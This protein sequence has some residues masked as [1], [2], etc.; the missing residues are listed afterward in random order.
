[1]PP[2]TSRTPSTAL[3]APLSPPEFALSALRPHA[4]LGVEAVAV[5]VLRDPD[6]DSVLL[7]PGAAEIGDEAGI[8]L[9]A[10]L[11][12]NHATGKAGEVTS[13]PVPLGGGE[14]AALRWV[15]LVGVGEQ[16]PADFRRAGAALARAAHGS[17]SVATSIPS[18]AP[19]D[20]LEAFVVGAMLGSFAFDLRSSPP[21]RPPV[22]RIVLAGIPDD[23]G[24]TQALDHALAVGGAGWRARF[25]ATV[26]SNIKNPQW[27]ADQAVALAEETGLRSRVWDVPDL[28]DGGFGGILGIGQA[29]ETPPRLI[30]LEYTPAKGARKAPHVVLVGKGITFDTGG[31][32]IKP[33]ESMVNMKRDMTGGAVVMAVLGALAEVGCPVRVTGL[34]AAAENAVGGNA[35]RPGDVVRHYGGRTTEVTN[36]DAEGR[37]VMADALAYAVDKLDPAVVVDVATLTGAM[38]VALGQQVGGYFANN[39][40]LARLIREAGDAAGEPFWRFPLAADYEEKLSSPVADADNAPGGPGAITAALFLQHFVGKVPWAHLDIASVGDAPEDDYEWSK[41]PTGFG[42]RA[43]LGWLG[44]SDPLEGIT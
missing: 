31:L 32:S 22:G 29:S 40:A 6:G 27:L 3:P 24:L 26:P 2:T 41:G 18:L 10:V 28:E 4:I 20:G 35:L 36:T 15:F 12:L 23:A 44:S 21:E 8:D 37:V 25:L 11:D 17:A 1:M 9:L 5:P 16:R 14:N 13:V 38:K 7:G 34:V 39:D 19:E 30:A 33:A 42:A 43:L